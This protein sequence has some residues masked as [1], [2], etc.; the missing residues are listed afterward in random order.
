MKRDMELIRELMLFIEENDRFPED[1][2]LP[3]VSD[4]LKN[5]HLLLLCE[6]ELIAGAGTVPCDDGSISIWN[7]GLPRLSW[8]GHEFLD[9]ARDPTTWESSKKTLKDAGKDLS[10]VTLAVLQALLIDTTKRAIGL[11]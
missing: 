7:G 3:K 6:A 10:K 11:P 4:Q 5:Y 8:K 1:H 2:E 9:A